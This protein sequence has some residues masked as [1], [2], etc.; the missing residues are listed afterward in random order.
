MT[1]SSTA[2]LTATVT[3]TAT[4]SGGFARPLSPSDL[5][6]IGKTT[7]TDT[8][9]PQPRPGDSHWVMAAP[10]ISIDGKPIQFFVDLE[11]PVNLTLTLFSLSGEKVFEESVEGNSGLNTLTWNLENQLGSRVASGLYVYVLT[12]DDETSVRTH[13]GKVVVL[14]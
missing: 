10:N 3:P 12:A 4:L 13:E 14:H 11:K 8:P 1:P 9:S 2:T 5:A 6:E 7:P